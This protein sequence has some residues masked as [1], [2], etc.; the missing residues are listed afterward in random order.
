MPNLYNRIKNR[1]H[2]TAQNW[3][4]DCGFSKQLA[5][6]RMIADIGERAGFHVLAEWARLK[7]DAWIL[8]YLQNKLQTVIDKYQNDTFMGIEKEDAP[9]WVCWWSG[10]KN[11]PALVKQCIK[12]IRKNAGHHPVCL[13]SEKNYKEYLELSENIL[14][15]LD[16]GAMCIANFT[17]YLRFSLL[18]KY[19]GLW[20]DATIFCTNKIPTDYFMAPIFTCRSNLVKTRYVSNMRWTSFCLG[21]WKDSLFYRF[22]KEALET[23]WQDE[24]EAIDYLLVDY[25]IELAHKN[26]PKVKQYID[27]IPYNN[28]HRDDLQAAMNKA[29]PAGDFWNIIQNDTILYK[30]SWRET[31]LSKTLEGDES[32]YA[33][34]LKMDI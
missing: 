19:G 13:I 29:L 2:L 31:Y 10:E 24:T 3:K 12:S 7:K 8:K 25:I 5:W 16:S 32:V 26:L 14:E 15:K 18:E 20:L 33:F 34:F 9:I 17:D 27:K 28:I 6:F 30:L 1:Y 23:Y 22:C 4:R 11:A 21:G